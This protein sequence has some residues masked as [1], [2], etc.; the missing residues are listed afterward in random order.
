MVPR[1]GLVTSAHSA[2]N[3]LRVATI[4]QFDYIALT[5]RLV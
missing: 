3:D 4:R 5:L 2:K 1:S